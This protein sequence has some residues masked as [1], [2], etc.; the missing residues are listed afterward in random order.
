MRTSSDIDILIDRNN[1]SKAE[2]ILENTLNYKKYV[3]NY[4]DVT[5]VTPRG[6]P[7]ELHFSIN[8][9]MQNL[10]KM[11]NKVWEYSK[12]L[13]N[14]GYEYVQSNEYFFFHNIAHMAY[15]F[16]AGGC[17]IRACID[18]YLLR[19][20]LTYD[21]SELREMCSIAG[22]DKFYKVL[23]NLL[24]VWFED[25]IATDET[26]AMASYIIKGGNFGTLETIIAAK[27]SVQGN[28]YRYAFSRL[29]VTTEHLSGYYPIVK[30]HKV[31][32]PIYQVKRWIDRAKHRG[33][34]ESY[35]EEFDMNAKIDKKT[36]EDAKKTL[37]MLDL[38]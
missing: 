15:P 7:I 29:W 19:N 22:L 26:D 9:N 34:L 25:G 18:C 27:Q 10:D 17:G 16:V 6:I 36:V 14:D 38:I 5:F 1:L 30:K 24:D 2:N 28:K 35:R 23:M 11:L 32:I 21:E 4:H 31:L 8:E 3:D 37:K 13:K 33:G 12:P 20:K